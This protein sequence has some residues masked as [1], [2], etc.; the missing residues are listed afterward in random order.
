MTDD[1]IIYRGGI[2]GFLW[3]RIPQA[4]PQAF[5]SFITPWAVIMLSMV[6]HAYV[7]NGQIH[8]HEVTAPA[9]KEAGWNG[10]HRHSERERGWME[11]H[12]EW[13]SHDAEGAK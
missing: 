4:D 9:Y 12:E 3:H 8:P 11:Q 1:P 10:E 5:Q 13:H 2:G 7:L 6:A